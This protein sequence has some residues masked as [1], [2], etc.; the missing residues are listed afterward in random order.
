MASITSSLTEYGKD[1]LDASRKNNCRY[2]EYAF[3]TMLVLFLIQLHSHYN[4]LKDDRASIFDY[5]KS[6]TVMIVSLLIGIMLW[7]N[8]KQG[9]CEGKILK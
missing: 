2:T 8:L 3:V 1:I 7:I 6:M 5:L 4:K 9:T